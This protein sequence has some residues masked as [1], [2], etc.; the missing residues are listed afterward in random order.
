[1]TDLDVLPRSSWTDRDPPRQGATIA[2]SDRPGVEFHHTVGTYGLPASDGP[3]VARAVDDDHRGRGWN[4]IFYNALIDTDGRIVVCRPWAWQSNSPLFTIVFPG[5]YDNRQLTD[6]QKGAAAELVAHLRRG[7]VGEALRW[8]GDRAAVGC[9][10]RNVIAWIRA[11]GPNQEDDMTPEDL[12]R[13]HVPGTDESF[14]K[15]TRHGLIHQ[16]WIRSEGIPAVLASVEAATEAAEAAA[17]AAERAAAGDQ[18]GAAELSGDAAA[19][20]RRLRDT[21]LAV[22]EASAAALRD[23]DAEED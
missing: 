18:A 14:A 21:D 16:R 3:G 8:H 12:Y 2:Y 20:V 7:G 1:M 22:L 5:N 10:G 13:S 11:D 6:A 23:L 17:K 4:G 19:I 9:P 15:H